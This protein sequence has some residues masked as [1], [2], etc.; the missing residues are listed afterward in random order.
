MGDNPYEQPGE[1][2][3]H[4]KPR[5][6]IPWVGAII[7]CSIIAFLFALMLPA[8][9]VSRPAARRTQCIEQSETGR[10]GVAQLRGRSSR[11]ASSIYR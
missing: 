9:R 5:W 7:A 4:A 1:L 3:G 8:G 6:R 2:G 11:L 10:S